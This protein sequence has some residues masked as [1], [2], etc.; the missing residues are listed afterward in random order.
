[1]RC[2]FCSA[3]GSLGR[4]QGL[5]ASCVEALR[6]LR[7]D[8]RV[9]ALGLVVACFEG[10]IYAFV[11]NWT[12]ALSSKAWPPPEGVILSLF[13]M[14]CMCGASASTLMAPTVKPVARLTVTA[15]VGACALALAAFG[16]GHSGT[17]I[18]CFIAF[19]VFEFCVGVYYPSVGILKSKVVPEH[20]RGMVFNLY[21][22]PLNAV[23][24]FSKFLATFAEEV[25]AGLLLSG[26]M[27]LVSHAP[28][29]LLSW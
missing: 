1:M 15:G 9:C 25:E 28:V 11:F 3:R 26:W 29:W 12:P 24:E 17:V 16:C 13:M 18:V 2:C 20:V 7:R 6:L 8:R 14:A 23:V 10:S 22:I 5:K 4:R 21:R 19:C 27:F